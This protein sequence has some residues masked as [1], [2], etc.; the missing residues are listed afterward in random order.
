MFAVVVAFTNT[1]MGTHT[2]PI[3]FLLVGCGWD[4]NIATVV[5]VAHASLSPPVFLGSIEMT[6]TG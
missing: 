4:G 6:V 5:A 2:R 3:P 1:A